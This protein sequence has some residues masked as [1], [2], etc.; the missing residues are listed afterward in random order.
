MNNFQIQKIIFIC[1]TFLSIFIP[2][3]D[4]LSS[5]LEK[6]LINKQKN[7]FSHQNKF[8]DLKIYEDQ[9]LTNLENTNSDDNPKKKNLN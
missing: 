9:F 3:G 8:P 1:L 2:P 5:N 4:A 6:T 7:R